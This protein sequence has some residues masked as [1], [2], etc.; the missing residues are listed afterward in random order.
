MDYVHGAIS[1]RSIPWAFPNSHY[2]QSNFRASF[3]TV[4]SVT[5]VGDFLGFQ[6][7]GSNSSRFVAESL[8]DVIDIC[9]FGLQ[10]AVHVDQGFRIDYPK[11]FS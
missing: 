9:E 11:S 6:M 2:A 8:D 1:K 7:Y 5:G 4:I 3:A 10:Q